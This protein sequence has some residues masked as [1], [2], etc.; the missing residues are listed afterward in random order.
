MEAKNKRKFEKDQLR[1][2]KEIA[3]YK[4]K[5]LEA[6][7]ILANQDLDFDDDE[8]DD[9]GYHDHS[10]TKNSSQIPQQHQNLKNIPEDE[11]DAYLDDIL[12]RNY[13]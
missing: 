12:N 7:E 5:K 2:K 8:D 6:Q 9:F 1:K 3:E 10:H 11:E 4:M 13:T